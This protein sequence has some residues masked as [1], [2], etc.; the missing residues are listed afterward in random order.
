MDSDTYA[1]SSCALMRVVLF[2][3]S[4]G[5]ALVCRGEVLQSTFAEIVWLCPSTSTVVLVATVV[6]LGA[7]AGVPSF[8][9]QAAATVPANKS[10]AAP[11]TRA[12]R[13]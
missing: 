6:E 10:A 8:E 4:G 2:P 12:E 3:D 7:E 11:R 9:E 5:V 13:G 1:E